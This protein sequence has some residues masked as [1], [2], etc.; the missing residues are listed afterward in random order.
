M[1]FLQK[2]RRWMRRKKKTHSLYIYYLWSNSENFL[3]SFLFFLLPLSKLYFHISRPSH[4]KTNINKRFVHYY[5][6]FIK[7][8]T[9]PCRTNTEITWVL[10]WFVFIRCFSN[11]CYCFSFMFLGCHTWNSTN[12]VNQILNVTAWQCSFFLL[13]LLV[14][15]RI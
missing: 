6:S 3:F 13:F 15:I 11:Y 4:Y 9:R 14:K 12:V 8:S 10:W 7:T 5:I 2:E 1:I